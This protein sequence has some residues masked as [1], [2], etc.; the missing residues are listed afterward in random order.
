[1]KYLGHPIVGD[2]VYGGEK[3]SRLYLHAGAL[4]ITLPGG[5]RTTFKVP[6]PEDFVSFFDKS[7]V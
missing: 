6:M 5:K 4:E 2:V 1:M 7:E 3:A